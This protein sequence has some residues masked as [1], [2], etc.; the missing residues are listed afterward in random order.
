[1]KI[2]IDARM[3]GPKCAGL[4]RYIKQLILNLEKLDKENQYIIFLNK[5]NFDSFNPQE[6]NFKKLLVNIPWY[7]WQEQFKFLNI[8]NK[9]KL[10]LMHFPHFNVPIFYKRKFI[11]TVHDLIMYHFPRPEASTKSKL[12]FFIKDKVHRL[13]LKNACERAVKILT[14]SEFTRQ[15]LVNILAIKKEKIKV[16][17]QAPFFQIKNILDKTILKTHNLENKRYFL[18]VGSA[19]PHKNLENL[20]KA[21]NIFNNELGFK[22]YYL[23]LVG[24]K[25]YF[26]ERLF[27]SLDYKNSQNIIFTDFIIDDD[28]QVLYENAESYIFPSLYEGFGLPSLEAMS[29]GIPVLSSNAS[30]LPEILADAAIYFDPLSP[31]NIADSLKFFIE[32]K[33]LQMELQ[34][35]SRQHVKYFSN[36]K[37]AVETLEEY[38]KIFR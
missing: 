23:V 6:K 9:E 38:K 22:N 32:D 25:S 12:V 37:M 33:D 15:D 29:Y 28:L 36:E 14:T 34:Q 7:S 11:V 1:M 10:D 2:G 31:E 8:L 16:V 26:Y 3:Y 13:V 4:G 30:C 5:E 19:Y 21:W 17:Y 20:V 18:Y 27:N 24:K 35:R